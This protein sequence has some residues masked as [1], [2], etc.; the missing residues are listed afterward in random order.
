M[1]L[2]AHIARIARAYRLGENEDAHDAL[3]DFVDLLAAALAHPQLALRHAAILAALD[4]V[5]DAKLRVDTLC[6]A[7]LLEYR[8]APLLS[9]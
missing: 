9:A 6:L 7:D 8:I 3:C 2:S 4:E 5:L 1:E